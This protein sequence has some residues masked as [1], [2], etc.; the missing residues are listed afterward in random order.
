MKARAY[1]PPVTAPSEGL[2]IVN[3]FN[4]FRHKQI[5]ST[6]YKVKTKVD[7]QLDLSDL[8]SKLYSLTMERKEK[9]NLNSLPNIVSIP[10]R[11]D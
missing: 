11:R 10:D 8:I 5:K 4:R 6:I 9:Q 2:S 1:F 3:Y 7:F